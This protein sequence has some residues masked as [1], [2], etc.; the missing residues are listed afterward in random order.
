MK[1]FEKN[2]FFIIA[3]LVLGMLI[4]GMGITANGREDTTLPEGLASA[5]FGTVSGLFYNGSSYVREFYSFVTDLSELRDE[6]ENLKELN[7]D[8]KNRLTDYERMKNENLELKSLLEFK[9]ENFQYEYITASVV[10]IDPDYGFNVFVL[11]RGSNDGVQN[12]MSVV[13]KEGLV[14]RIVETSMFT[15]KVI[16]VTDRNSMFNGI[17]VRTGEYIRLTGDEDYTIKGFMDM[18][19]DI[20]PGDIFITSGLTG[21]FKKD[22]VIGEALEVETPQG[23]LEKHIKILPAVDMEM[24]KNVLII[25]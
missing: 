22:L 20:I 25:K 6:N 18:D 3:A 15:S 24:I 9:E 8:Y 23:K 16:A 7:S 2:K 19:A 13:I 11:N 4:T 21:S 12:N 14:G 17:C 10:S 1:F 5:G